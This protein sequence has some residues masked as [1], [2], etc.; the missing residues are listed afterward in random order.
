MAFDGDWQLAL[1]DIGALRLQQ[2]RRAWEA[3]DP[4]AAMVEAEELLDE[5]P[6]NLD[7]LLLVADAALELGDAAVAQATFQQV[8]EMQDDLASAWSGY[9]VACYEL[10]D[11]QGCLEASDH[12]LSLDDSLAEAHFYRGLVLDH[13]GDFQGGRLSLSRATE[14]DS[15]SFPTIP[16]LDPA[17]AEEALVQARA[18]LAEPMRVWLARVPIVFERYPSLDQLRQD[19]MPLSPSSPALYV[20][21]PPDDGRD[22][23]LVEPDRMVVYVGNLERIAALGADLSVILATALRAEAL[24][25]L[26]LADDQLPLQA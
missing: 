9:A 23:F 11:M 4:G 15:T 18:L 22:P 6:D 26:G 13:Q 25:W 24:D 17:E 1:T 5:E 3:R 21:S 12:A 2:A 20:G 8:L 16:S 7:A 19:E 10:T 14:L